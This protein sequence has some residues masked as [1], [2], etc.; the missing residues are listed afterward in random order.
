MNYDFVI[1]GGGSAGCILADRLSASGRHRVLLLE[2]GGDDSALRFRVPIG[3]VYTYYD[4]QHNWMYYSEPEP[5]LHGRKLYVPRGKVLG[6]SG[7]INAMIY[8]RGQAR[9]FADW[10]AAAG[11]ADW[12]FEKVLPYYRRMESHALGASAWH[13][14]DGP[15]HITPMRPQAHP[16]CNDFLTACQQLGYPLTQDFNGAQF[17]GGGIYDINT[18]NGLRD[19]SSRAYLRRAAGRSN[20]IIERERLV[21]RILFDGN[22]RAT[23]VVSNGRD[24]RFEC[25][26]SGEVILC[27]G[28]VGT[29]Q[30]LQLSGVGDEQLLRSHGI[31]VVHHAPAVGQRLQDHVCASYYYRARRSTLN[32]ELGAWPGRLRAGLDYLLFRR[33]PLALSVNQAGGFF[34]ASP[35]APFANI[36]LYFNPLSYSIPRDGSN[37]LAPEPYSGFLVAFSPC[38]PSS[39]GSVQIA[40]SRAQ[41]APLIRLNFLATEQDQQEVIQASRL[42]RGLFAAPALRAVTAQEVRPGERVQNDA[43]MLQ[44]FR[45]EAGSIYHLCGS[46]AMGSDASS[47][48]VSARLQVHG[49]RGLRIADASIFP[50]VTSGNINAPTMMVAEKAAE[51]ILADHAAVP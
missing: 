9:D 21:E 26:A 42:V 1:V 36:Q 35:Q 31:A 47:S 10:S 39:R 7:S 5:H 28:A 16:L 27:A 37:N 24:G 6:G 20:L 41:D 2:A 8:I 38:R 4:P 11:S 15:I 34:R 18:R 44:Y 23:G 25:S 19:S 3:Y 17:E 51:L 33:G 48:V 45:E 43:E 13:G 30:L 49:L 22:G 29:P 40:S 46:C 14:A 50:N 12:S 32:D